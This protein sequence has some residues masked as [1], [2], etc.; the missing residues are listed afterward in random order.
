MLV[1]DNVDVSDVAA[2][3]R[4]GL[5]YPLIMFAYRVFCVVQV[6]ISA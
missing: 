4:G 3:D 6:L 2:L 5:K 1:D